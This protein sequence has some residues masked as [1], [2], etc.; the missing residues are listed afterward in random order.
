[1]NQPNEITVV[2]F[3]EGD[4]IIKDPAAPRFSSIE[5]LFKDLED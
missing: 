4:K 2:A 3:E 1:M 5:D